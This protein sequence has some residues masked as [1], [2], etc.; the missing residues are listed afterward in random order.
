MKVFPQKI[1]YP[2][3]TLSA[4]NLS[5][6]GAKNSDTEPEFG[7]GNFE[8]EYADGVKR[9]VWTLGGKENMKMNSEKRRSQ[10]TARVVSTG[11]RK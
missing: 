6:I 7:C 11:E 5:E 4:R 1:P 10:K 2:L 8:E 3:K 9:R